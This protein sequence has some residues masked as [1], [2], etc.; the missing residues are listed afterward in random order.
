M[1]CSYLL[2]LHKY[3]WGLI[4]E[5]GCVVWNKKYLVYVRSVTLISLSVC[6]IWTKFW[7]LL[8]SPIRIN[9]WPLTVMIEPRW[10]MALVW[11]F[12]R[13][14]CHQPRFSVSRLMFFLRKCCFI[15]KNK[16]FIFS[17]VVRTVSEVSSQRINR[18]ACV[19]V[20]HF[21]SYSRFFGGKPRVMRSL[22]RTEKTLIRPGGW[23]IFVHL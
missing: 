5:F 2:R 9:R 19:L 23:V 11:V 8:L 1:T 21:R 14:S 22:V 20:Q 18:S 7:H 17:G 12:P 13:C 15:Q 16:C 3:L 4:T 10:C 6:A